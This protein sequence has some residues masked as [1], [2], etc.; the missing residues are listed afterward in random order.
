MTGVLGS[1]HWLVLL[2]FDVDGGRGG[3]GP[4]RVNRWGGAAAV[5]A[6]CLRLA[7]LGGNGGRP[8]LA[9]ACL[10]WPALVL[11]MGRAVGD[12]ASVAARCI[13][14]FCSGAPSLVAATGLEPAAAVGS[15]GLTPPAAVVPGPSS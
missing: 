13:L 3:G 2:A 11:V 15:G 9:L 1:A 14:P 5:A 6:A 10:C 4:I 7:E 12:S 8:L